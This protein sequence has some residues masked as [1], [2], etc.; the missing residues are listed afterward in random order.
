[1]VR[2]DNIDRV[3]DTSLEDFD[4]ILGNIPNELDSIPEPPP[5][6][7][8]KKTLKEYKKKLKA[9]YYQNKIH[10]ILNLKKKY[11]ETIGDLER[12]FVYKESLKEK[13]FGRLFNRAYLRIFI[14]MPYGT[15][16]EFR[17]NIKEGTIKAMKGKYIINLKAI[18]KFKGRPSLFYHHNNPNP[19]IFDANQYPYLVSAESLR[20][21]LNA[22][23]VRDIFV[24]LTPLQVAGMTVGAIAIFVFGGILFFT[25]AKD[26][27]I[28]MLFPMRYLYER[29]NN[30][31]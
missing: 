11:K 1:M 19:I 18:I 12:E 23:V 24:G 25:I 21:L 14:I 2:I 22:N 30:N 26:S 16:K 4:K 28:F 5:E 13:I 27:F 29:F 31:K 3:S 6:L 8:D 10:D 20:H 9:Q 17:K 7:A 15:I